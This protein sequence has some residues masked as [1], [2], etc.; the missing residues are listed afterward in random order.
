MKRKI[1]M[2][3]MLLLM[4]VP[5]ILILFRYYQYTRE[6]KKA[7]V[8]SELVTSYVVPAP[9]EY[10]KEGSFSVAP[11]DFLD[12]AGLRRENPDVV[13]YIR[14]DE[15]PVDY[16]VM[17][18]EV[19]DKYL[20]AGFKGEPSLY[21]SIFMDNACYV[22]GVNQVLYGHNMKSGKMFAALHNYVNRDFWETHPYIKFIDEKEIGIYEVCSVFT[23]SAGDKKLQYS[24]IPYAKE[25]LESLKTYISESGGIWYGDFTWNDRLLTLGTC[26]YTKRD[27]RL[28]VVAKRVGG[29]EIMK[30]MED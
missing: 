2:T 22:G 11:K 12:I 16:P 8:F 1:T 21:G 30:E 26:E 6:D 15:T 27:G 3:V 25:E 5:V 13:G 29:I 7:E 19:Q 4:V 24:L 20:R 28:F 9:L 14:I 23:A 17:K 18:N 10:V